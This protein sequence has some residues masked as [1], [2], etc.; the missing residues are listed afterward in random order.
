MHN[1]STRT[2]S[3]LSTTYSR[4][5]VD[6]HITDIDPEFMRDYSAKEHTRIVASS[7][8]ESVMVYACCHNGNCYYPTKVGHIHANLGG[9]DIF[10]Q[11]VEQ[12]KQKGIIPTAYYTVC[13]HND[14]AKN[15]PSWRFVDVLGRSNSGRYWLSCPNNPQYRQFAKDQLAE[16]AAY[17]VAGIFIDM[18]FWPGICVCDCC[19][20]KYRSR[21]G[22]EI[23]EVLDWTSPAWLDF[24]NAREVWIADFAKDLTAHIKSIKPQ[25]L[26]TH[27]FAPVLLGWY[28]GMSKAF[29]DAVDY[30]SGDFYGGRDQHRL[31]AKIFESFTVQEP[32]EFMTSRCVNLYDHTSTKSDEEMFASAASTLAHGGV[33]FFID[34]INPNGTLQESFYSRLGKV[35]AKLKPFKDKIAQAKRLCVYLRQWRLGC[36]C[37]THCC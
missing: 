33:Y 31:G 3:K 2:K 27:Q 8:V 11:T 37:S 25:M 28:L 4:L 19:R 17:D 32:F 10:G 23:P 7:G 36:R 21:S 6:N 15:H 18:S 30:P 5:L 34:A 14:S 35:S 16:I 1:V 29:L 9:K 22:V 20:E 26:V 13:W 24:Q 12:F